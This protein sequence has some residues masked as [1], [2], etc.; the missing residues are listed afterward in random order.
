MDAPPAF[1]EFLPHS[2]QSVGNTTASKAA[3]QFPKEGGGW[4]FVSCRRERRRTS[5]SITTPRSP[6]QR[7]GDLGRLIPSSVRRGQ[8]GGALEETLVLLFLALDAMARPRHRFQAFYLDFFLAG[9]AQRPYVPF[10]RRSK[11]SLTICRRRRFSSLWWKRNSL[12]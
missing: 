4:H 1:R 10:L 3:E 6:P 9:Q 12:V 2:R 8:R 7:G 11:A 5:L